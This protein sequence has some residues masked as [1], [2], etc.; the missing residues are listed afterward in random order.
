MN[1]IL[2]DKDLLLCDYTNPKHK[3]AL[4]ELINGYINCDTEKLS[5]KFSEK[6]TA[7]LLPQQKDLLAKGLADNANAITLFAVFGGSIAG[8]LTAFMNFS[9]FLCAPCINIHDIFIKKEFRRKGLAKK[10][11]KG[12]EEIAKNNG[13]KKITLEVRKDN[14]P[15]QTLYASFGFCEGQTPM[16]FYIKHIE[17]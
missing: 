10:L 16:Y 3:T 11:L 1:L 14:T 4:W 6:F 13:C 12:I 9:T 17:T 2:N 8:V 7:E 5:E 15:A